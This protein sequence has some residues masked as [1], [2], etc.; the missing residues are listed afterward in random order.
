MYFFRSYEKD[1]YE[2]TPKLYINAMHTKQS[3]Q[4]MSYKLVRYHYT[5]APYPILGNIG[6]LIS[7]I[8][9]DGNNY[10]KSRSK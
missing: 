2:Y 10:T 6:I 4:S 8:N 9:G 7:D 5:Y 1:V 3:T